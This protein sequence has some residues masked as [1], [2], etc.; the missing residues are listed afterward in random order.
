[1]VDGIVKKIVSGDVRVA[2]RLI[3]DIEDGVPGTRQILK[4]LYKHTG[5]AYVVGSR[6]SN[7]DL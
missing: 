7:L 5:K 2:A 6:G 4:A 3:R 1:M